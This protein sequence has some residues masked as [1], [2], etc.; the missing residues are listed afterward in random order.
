M[1]T[2][3]P[4]LPIIEPVPAG[5]P[6]TNAWGVGKPFGDKPTPSSI[7][8]VWSGINPNPDLPPP[9]PEPLNGTLILPQV[10]GFPCNFL[11]IKNQTLFEVAYQSAFSTCI[12]FAVPLGLFGFNS[13]EGIGASLFFGLDTLNFVGGTCQVHIPEI[14]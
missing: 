5:D 13:L 6:C 9:L 1:G 8:A 4:P 12:I 10:A 11:L 3:I 7:V 2:P 14:I